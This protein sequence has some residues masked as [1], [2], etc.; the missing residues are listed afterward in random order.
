VREPAH[1]RFAERATTQEAKVEYLDLAEGWLR[2]S[3]KLETANDGIRHSD[4]SPL[5]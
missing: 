3:E 5:P 2:L 4:D 1:F